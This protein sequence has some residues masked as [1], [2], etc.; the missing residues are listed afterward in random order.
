MK[1]EVETY[2]RWLKAAY[3]YY[4]EAGED[5]GMSDAEWDYVGRQLIPDE[6]EE[7]KGTQYVPGQSLFWLSKDKYPS[8]VKE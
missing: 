2:R 1:I 3:L 8:W 4:W 6:W 5:T 7:L